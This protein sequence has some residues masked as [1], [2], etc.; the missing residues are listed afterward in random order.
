MNVTNSAADLIIANA[1]ELLTC[2]GRGSAFEVINNGWLA[3]KDE[4]I[5]AAGRE[6]EVASLFDKNHT[7][8][9]DA[10]G[11]VVAPG[12]IDCHTHLVF[13]G[14]RVE[15][16]AAG[17]TGDDLSEL[18][19]KGIKTG[20]LATVEA[21][22]QASERELFL[23]AMTRL[24]RMIA[25]GT[26]TVESKSGY[27]LSTD[28][29]IKILQVNEHLRRNSPAD[30]I[31]TF[32]GAHGWPHDLP[33]AQY[34]E[35]LTGEMI[36][37]VAELDLAEFC[38]IWCD[39]GYYSAEESEKILKAALGYGLK[40]KIHTDAYSYVGGSDL[41]AEMRMVS[42]DHLNYTPAA[43]MKKL[44]EAGVVGVLLP[45]LDF[46]VRHERPFD[47]PAMKEQGMTVALATNL[48]PGC[49]AESM[50]FVM[51][52]ACRFYKMSPAEALLAATIGGAR[53]LNLD[54]DYGSLEVGKFADFQVWDVPA[55][56]H[57]I[58][59]LGSNVVEKVFKKG[60]LIADN[61]AS[62]KPAPGVAEVEDHD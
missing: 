58:Y 59:R 38:D 33:R 36:P 7:E 41:A 31:S 54:R 3:V 29:E 6:R 12:F 5:M 11:K 1:S 45:A 48:C 14:S 23:A 18:E 35:I 21:T 27:G 52:L 10:A 15:E 8:L 61:H 51:V 60:R 32:L 17:L 40:P 26:T 19:R 24:D 34:M 37:R 42:A 22:R 25:S 30:I 57:V 43:V 20:I 13:G 39:H 62:V 28:A 44:A 49:W 47:Y 50:Q 55:Y 46:A 16:Y 2:A 53:A 4:R 9:F 56:E